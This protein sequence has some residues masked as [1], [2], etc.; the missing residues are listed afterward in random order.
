MML[1]YRRGHIVAI[2]FLFFALAIWFA[3]PVILRYFTTPLQHPLR[4]VVG[5]RLSTSFVPKLSERHVIEVSMKPSLSM[6]RMAEIIGS[7]DRQHNSR[8]KIDFSLQARGQTIPAQ[9]KGG[10]FVG[11][12]V[13]FDLASF[14][15]VRGERYTLTADVKEA[16]PDLGALNAHLVVRIPPLLE[17]RLLSRVLAT[18]LLA[19]V[20]MVVAFLAFCIQVA[21]SRGLRNVMMSTRG[22]RSYVVTT[23][24]FGAALA[25]WFL[26]PLVAD[27]LTTPL[28]HRFAMV[29]GEHVSL[30]FVPKLSQRHYI[31]VELERNLPFPRLQEIVGGPLIEE[32][33]PDSRPKIDFRLESHGQPLEIQRERGEHWGRLVGFDLGSFMAKRGETYILTANVASAESDVRS[34]NANLFVSVHPMTGETFYFRVLAA[35]LLAIVFAVVALFV[36]SVPFARSRGVKARL[37]AIRL[38]S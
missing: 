34:L 30:P 28:H 33:P 31:S 27:R 5:Q 8:P 37:S 21:Y 32:E 20:S 13:G 22:R 23:I 14:E 29:T 25:F 3:P 35:R 11:E 7:I 16:E 4:L 9:H 1:K 17:Q 10:D 18:R 26:S 24:L 15:A 12:T 36:F 6:H 2:V 19:I 38:A